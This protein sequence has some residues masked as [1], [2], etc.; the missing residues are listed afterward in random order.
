M[1][2]EVLYT[3]KSYNGQYEVI[4]T[5]TGG[6]VEECSCEDDESEEDPVYQYTLYDVSEESAQEMAVLPFTKD[7]AFY[8]F[9]SSNEH[10][11]LFGKDGE[12][13]VYTIAS[14]E[15]RT[16]TI[17]ESGLSYRTVSPF[18]KYVVG[19]HFGDRE[20]R[21]WNTYT[22]EQATI[23][24]EPSWSFV[25]FSNDE[26]LMAFFN[27]EEGE[28]IMFMADLDDVSEEGE[29]AVEEVEALND[30]FMISDSVFL[31]D[32]FFYVVGNVAENP[33]NWVLHQYDPAT[34][35]VRRVREYISG[36]RKVKP[37]RQ[38]GDRTLKFL[39]GEGKNKHVALYDSDADEVR[40]IRAVDPSP[41]SENIDRSTLTVDGVHGVLWRPKNRFKGQP[42][43]LFVWL[44][45]GPIQQT[46]LNYQPL[47]IYANFDELLERLVESGSYVLKIDYCGS[48]G[49]GVKFSDAL[50]G[51]M[52]ECDVEDVV[53]MT[54]VIQKRYRD[55]DDTYL[56]GLSYGGYL[57]P[58][59]LVDHQRYFDGVIAVNGL[60][61][62]FIFFEENPEY[63]SFRWYFNGALPDVI[64]LTKNFDLFLQASTLKGLP[65]LEDDKIIL[66]IYGEDDETVPPPQ[67]REFFYL[68]RS[69]GKDARL[70]EIK[71]EG[72]LISKRS[73]LDLMCRYIADELDLENVPCGAA[74][75]REA[76]SAEDDEG[77]E[78]A[79]G[80]GAVIEEDIVVTFSP[81]DNEVLSD[82]VTS[83]TI[84]FDEG[85]YKD[86]DGEVFT[87][88]DLATF[89]SL[90]TEDVNGYG[91]PFSV[92]MNEENTMITIEPVDNLPSGSVYVGISAGY[93]TADGTRGKSQSAIFVND[94]EEFYIDL[95]TSLKHEIGSP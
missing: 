91:I 20:Y 40:V 23:S 31:D 65:D 51:A 81:E 93:Y 68:A 45:G 33:Y 29:V 37:I 26:S 44:H 25:S 54:R 47:G 79:A 27:Q 67:S 83:I 8:T 57:G 76:E 75:S 21:I 61:D 84:T 3:R 72:H 46:S 34:K 1:L 4:K 88:S 36:G 62:W 11:M 13:M 92:S 86:V 12:L 9:S 78:R 85:V 41:A 16:I 43:H 66:L 32:G 15:V 22:G 71:D 42:K 49:Y 69:L 48:Y 30:L 94:I 39:I 17:S 14:E 74:E 64:D 60:I 10:V 35:Q 90:R 59:V 50:L 52:G 5:A 77:G 24:A 7:V 18:A 82:K 28:Q 95:F 53:D 89:V 80:E 70:L 73:S 58:R 87:E 6:S 2:R 63:D 55:I 56:I 19:Y 38:I